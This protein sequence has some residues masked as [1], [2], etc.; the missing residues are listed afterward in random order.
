MF[1]IDSN[2]LVIG[3]NE[4]K[5]NRRERKKNEIISFIQENFLSSFLSNKM[6]GLTVHKVPVTK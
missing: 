6:F 5:I 1:L 2:I 4:E 3:F